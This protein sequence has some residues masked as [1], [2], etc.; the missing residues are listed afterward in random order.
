MEPTSH[1]RTFAA[2][3]QPVISN[4]AIPMALP[5]AAPTARACVGLGVCGGL[6]LGECVVHGLDCLGDDRECWVGDD[7]AGEDG[8]VY[9]D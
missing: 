8:G 3:D 7:G 1:R 9:D 2:A 6:W 4:M 5:T